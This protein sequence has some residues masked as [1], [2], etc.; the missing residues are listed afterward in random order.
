MPIK[1]LLNTLEEL[2]EKNITNEEEQNFFNEYKSLNGTTDA[3]IKSFEGHFGI[4][5]P[6]D[7]K[8][9]YKIKNGSKY[10]FELLYTT[11]EDSC[12]P[13]T[14]LSLEQIIKAKEYFCDQDKL[15]E[16]YYA[17]EEIQ[18]LDKR[19]KPYLW[20]KKWIPFA[21]LPSGSLYLMLDYDPT[22]YGKTGQIILY[23]HD[24]DFIYYAAPTFTD[25]INDTIKN[26]NEG[27]YK[28]IKGDV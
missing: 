12:M 3:E 17:K 5:L 2:F 25:L 24:P 4:N 28:E 6:E 21:Q 18:K 9:Y 11:Y 15:L 14:I 22:E 8:E 13:F 10:P 26:M 27:W 16:K 1:N 20:N 19:I 23:V 7:V